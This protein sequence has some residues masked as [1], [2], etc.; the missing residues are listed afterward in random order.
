[1]KKKTDDAPFLA[2]AFTR[3]V[4]KTDARADAKQDTLSMKSSSVKSDE[5]F[6]W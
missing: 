4:K 2:K 1:M 5:I 6:A 3:Y